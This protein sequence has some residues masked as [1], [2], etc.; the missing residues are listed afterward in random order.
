MPRGD[1]TGPMGLGP[2]TGR[3]AGYC[4][5][6]P[7]PGFMNP[8]GGRLGLGFGYGRGLGRG[9]GRG[10]GRAYSYSYPNPY[11]IT[12]LPTVYGGGFY[13]PG[14]EPKQETEILTEEAKALRKQLEE[15]DK[16]ISELKETEKK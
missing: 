14:I 9:Y 12:P 5:G 11:P 10:F 6:Y 13:P 3:A 7:V 15:I 1:G 8:Y 2:M 4:A 16:R